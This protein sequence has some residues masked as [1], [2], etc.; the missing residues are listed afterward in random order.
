VVLVLED[1]AVLDAVAVIQA[2]RSAVHDACRQFLQ[3]ADDHDRTTRRRAVEAIAGL[4]MLDD[5][6]TEQIRQ[7][8]AWRARH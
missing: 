1:D 8:A 7:L 6:F 3:I 4:A 2:R 5:Y